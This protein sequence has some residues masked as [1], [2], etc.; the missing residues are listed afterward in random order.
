MNTVLVTAV[1]SAAANA[2]CRS[3]RVAGCRV[4]GCDLYPQSWNVNA[5]QMEDFFQAP[6]A[7]DAEAY[8]AA[9]LEATARYGLSHIMPLTDVEVDAL[10]DQ[11]PRFAARG[12]RLCVPD[13][14]AA[15]L[16]RD[17]LQ[18]ARRLRESGVGRT[19][20]TWRPE[21]LP[22][23]TAYPLLLKPLHGRSSQGL[24][25]ARTEAQLRAA[26]SQREDYIVQ[27]YL[28]G[29]VVTVDVVRGGDGRVAAV[30]RREL[31]R[32]VN[33]LGTTVEILPD[34]PLCGVCAQIAGLAGIVG[35]V[36]M[37]FI[38]HDGADYFLEVNPRFS[39][40][41]GFTCLAGYDVP[42][43]NLRAHEGLP[44][45]PVEGVRGMILAQRYEAYVTKA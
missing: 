32:T 21:E 41:V 24:T 26:L 43:N 33:G 42:V 15:R 28:E 11:K 17:K 3:L 27:P 29:D 36:N 6:P 19:I 37:E 39:G 40:G 18:M 22:A 14:P 7:T 10:C 38:R 31:L 9:L 30:A 5:A 45:A 34:H 23:D 25:I 4:V 20:P 12:V 2:V 44:V 35:A 8:R 16:C 13:D 1:G